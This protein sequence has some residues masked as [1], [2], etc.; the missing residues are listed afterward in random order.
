[1]EYRS[2]CFVY[3]TF[4]FG[5][6]VPDF[7]VFICF[8]AINRDFRRTRFEKEDNRKRAMPFSFIPY[9]SREC[10]TSPCAARLQANAKK[11]PLSL[12]LFCNLLRRRNRGAI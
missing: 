4:P 9:R 11:T 3:I 10:G 7:V 6:I 2:G 5:F 1:M 12:G 8:T